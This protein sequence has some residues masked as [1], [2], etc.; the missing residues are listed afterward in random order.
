MESVATAQTSLTLATWLWL[1]VP[2]L[3][4]VGLSIVTYIGAAVRR[5]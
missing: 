4:C 2:M 5:R 3:A 1:L